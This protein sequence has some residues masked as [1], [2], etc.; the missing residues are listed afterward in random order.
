MDLQVLVGIEPSGKANSEY[1]P[2]VFRQNAHVTFLLWVAFE[3][4]Q[5]AVDQLAD[6]FRDVEPLR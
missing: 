6:L 5:C 1:Q 4:F 3:L 2:W